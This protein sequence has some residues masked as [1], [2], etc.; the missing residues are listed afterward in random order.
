M[1]NGSSEYSVETVQQMPDEASE[2]DEMQEAL[3][4]E[5]LL[6]DKGGEYS[7]CETWRIYEHCTKCS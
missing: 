6:Q 3:Q 4:T 2:K 7:C 5:Q 1:N